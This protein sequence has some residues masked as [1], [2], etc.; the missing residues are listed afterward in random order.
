MMLDIML[1]D[2]LRVICW[3]V[4][5]VSMTI[6]R[7]IYTVFCTGLSAGST[8]GACAGLVR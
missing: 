7:C 4:R 8:R 1:A 3:V 5:V 2:K 6:D